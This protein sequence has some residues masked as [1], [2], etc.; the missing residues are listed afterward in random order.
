LAYGDNVGTLTVCDAKTLSKIRDLSCGSSVECLEYSPD[1][2][3]I[4]SGHG[5]SAIRLW[6]AQTGRLQT[7]LV[8]HDRQLNSLAFSPDGRTLLSSSDDGSV[9]AWSVA[10]R[11]SLGIIARRVDSDSNPCKGL[12]S[13]S[14]DGRYLAI[15]FQ[16]NA[17]KCAGPM[18]WNIGSIEQH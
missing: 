12:F 18:I 10:H 16:S 1:G 6:D 11:R 14:A 7:K 5:D 3:V 13:L 4:A 2:F 8:G 17:V 15:G 9:R